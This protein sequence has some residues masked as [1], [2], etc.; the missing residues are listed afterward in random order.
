MTTPSRHEDDDQVSRQIR[1]FVNEDLDI[2][3]E[4]F[5]NEEGVDIPQ[6]KTWK[7][8]IEF[9]KKMNGK[10]FK[11]KEQSFEAE[12]VKLKVEKAKAEKLKL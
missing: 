6:R 12:A 7:N 3:D 1:E 2:D 11:K 8:V 10:L 9:N 4:V 5:I